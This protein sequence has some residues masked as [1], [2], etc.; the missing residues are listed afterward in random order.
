MRKLFRD[1]V[2]VTFALRL[3]Y[4]A[5]RAILIILAFTGLRSLPASVYRTIN[6]T[7]AIEHLQWP[8]QERR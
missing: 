3:R 8:R 6:W 5:S 2:G 7:D 4:A 1:G